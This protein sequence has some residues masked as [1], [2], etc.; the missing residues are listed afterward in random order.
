MN[1]INWKRTGSAIICVAGLCAL[2]T[3]CSSSPSSGDGELAIQNRIDEQSQGRIKLAKFEKSNG[4]QGVMNGFKIYAMDFNAEIEFTE[5]CKWITGRFGEQLSFQTSKPVAKP[6]SGFSWNSF[7]DDTTNPGTPVRSGQRAKLT[8]VIR[9]VK[10]EKGWAVDRVEL[11]KADV[12]NAG[13]SSAET[14]P[15]GQTPN[16]TAQTQKEPESPSPSLASLREKAEKG[17]AKAQYELGRVYANGTGVEK[18]TME[19][20]KWFRSSAEQG[21]AAGQNGL[22]WMYQFGEGVPEDYQQALRWFRLA[23]DQ[24]EPKAMANLGKMY[25]RGNGVTEDR[26]ESAR[27]FRK[28]AEAG[29]A[30][31]QVELAQAYANGWG[32]EQ[33]MTEAASWFRKAAD[34][35]LPDAQIELAQM[36]DEGRGVEQ[37]HARASEWY[38]KSAENFRKYAEQGNS[39]AQLRL[40][41]MY[42]TG[43]GLATNQNIAVEWYRKAAAS[44]N[45][46]VNELATSKIRELSTDPVDVARRESI[47]CVNNL[48]MIFLSFCQWALDHDDRWPFNVSTN[49]GRGIRGE[50]AGGTLEL[51]SRNS[52]GFDT[53][54]PSIF[55]VMSKELGETKYLVCPSDSERQLAADFLSL[56]SINVS[57]Q[58]RSGPNVN[59][60]NPNEILARCPAHGH[61]LFCGG[62]IQSEKLQPA[63]AAKERATLTV[64]L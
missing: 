1:S 7:L 8:G 5:D 58:V 18:N 11:T 20:L 21:Y 33:N 60:T 22:G 30:G 49:G 59:D 14:T 57:Y 15:G 26:S 28:A 10:K 41:E 25:F 23:A 24:G 61:I 6:G 19:A 38:R 48:R 39:V 42:E 32:V 47:A 34:Q 40:A 50:Y 36:Y 13:Q 62:R 9:F 3:G 64:T 52:D 31:G 4:A 43:K 63:R 51:C 27:L 46:Y 35:N 54:A 12:G 2:L 16:A 45:K 55:Q 29:D 56:R 17:D 44:N 37:S 53:S